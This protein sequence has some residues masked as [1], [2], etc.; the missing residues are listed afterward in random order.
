MT[1]QRY[2]PGPWTVEPR[3]NL[4][5]R[6]FVEAGEFRIAECITR[7]QEANARLIAAAPDLLATLERLANIADTA[8]S[9]L[10]NINRVEAERFKA[11]ARL[12]HDAIAKAKGEA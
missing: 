4:K 6:Q 7:D 10:W 9:V 5:A 1:T 3:G 12:A 2:T 8:A 11:D